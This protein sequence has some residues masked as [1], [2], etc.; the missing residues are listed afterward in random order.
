MRRGPHD[1]KDS[2]SASGGVPRRPSP[3]P[4]PSSLPL[5]EMSPEAFTSSRSVQ[6][7]PVAASQYGAQELPVAPPPAHTS[8]FMPP[9]PST[10]N[11]D[12]PTHTETAPNA[13]D[14][15]GGTA[16][17]V[18]F[19]IFSGFV[20]NFFALFFLTCKCVGIQRSKTP[21]FLFGWSIGVILLIICVY[22]WVFMIIA[23]VFYPVL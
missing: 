9:P 3:P 5:Q 12:A 22:P 16:I 11:Y 15:G 21:N 10:A 4:P 23:I 18:L 6:P 14:S 20:L 7:S 19:G 2:N 1:S 8:V 13:A 17:Y